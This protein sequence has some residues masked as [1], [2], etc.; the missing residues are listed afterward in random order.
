MATKA[1]KLAK[2]AGKRGGKSTI[3]SPFLK[4]TIP[5]GQAKPAPPLG[6]QLGQVYIQNR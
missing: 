1:G 5:A 6:P 2:A 3:F 4:V